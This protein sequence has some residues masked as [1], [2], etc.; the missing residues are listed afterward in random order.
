[1]LASGFGA[2]LYSNNRGKWTPENSGLT[3]KI[4]KSFAVNGNNI[5]AGTRGDGVYLTTDFGKKWV[6][7]NNGLLSLNLLSRCTR[8][9]DLFAGTDKGLF[10]STDNGSNLTQ[11]NQGLSNKYIN[12]LLANSSFMI[13]Y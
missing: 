9:S 5:F 3:K 10:L 8:G 1:M 13:A 4:I 11:M 12:T 2:L 7:K 6:P